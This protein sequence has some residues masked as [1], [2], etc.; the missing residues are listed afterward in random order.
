MSELRD[1]VAKGAG[2]G[3]MAGLFGAVVMFVLS[4]FFSGPPGS[5]AEVLRN[6]FKIGAFVFLV[7]CPMYGSLS[8]QGN[9]PYCQNEIVVGPTDKA[10][11][12]KTCQN[13]LL[14]QNNQLT[15]IAQ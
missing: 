7:G 5:M 12:C 9:C 6:C 8:K 13:R 1:N 15:K 10:T 4:F 14:V 11:T 3:L 2:M